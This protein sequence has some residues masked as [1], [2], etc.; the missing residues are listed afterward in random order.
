MMETFVECQSGAVVVLVE[1]WV[2]CVCVC[3]C[4]CVH[5]CVRARA[6]VR[7]RA[8]VCVYVCSRS[9]LTQFV[10][11]TLQSLDQHLCRSLIMKKTKLHLY[12]VSILPIMLYGSECWAMNKADMQRIDAVDQWCLRRILEHSLARLLSEMPTSVALP[13][14]HHFHPSLS[15]V[16]SLCLGIL[17]EWMRTQMLAEPSSNLRQRT[18]GD[19][20]GGR[21]Q[22]G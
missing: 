17:H 14:C 5:A 20:R 1:Q 4:A 10:M 2:W 22:P 8:C 21:A 9:T 16:I 7:V 6:C 12:R 19:H 15:P 11:P 3:V 13:T 18:G